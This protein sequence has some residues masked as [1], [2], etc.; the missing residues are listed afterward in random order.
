MDD[1][2][3]VSAVRTPIGEA[4]KSLATVP[5]WDLAEVACREAIARAAIDPAVFDDVI[6]G[7]TV[8]G[9]GNA[10]RYVGLA[11]GVPRDAP[12][13]T[14]VRVCATGLEAVLQA[15]TAGWA[16]TGAADRAG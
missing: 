4:G 16:G 5:A 15:A 6:L 10:G 9:G 7:E 11:V 12:G 2:V 13:V 14:V 1:A 3:I 8:G